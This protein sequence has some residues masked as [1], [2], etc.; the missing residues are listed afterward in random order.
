MH[1]S[2]LIIIYLALQNIIKV[3]KYMMHKI[4]FCTE[5]E[6]NKMSHKC[7]EKVLKEGVGR[8]VDDH[9]MGKKNPHWLKWHPLKSS[10]P[11]CNC[12]LENACQFTEDLPVIF[13][14]VFSIYHSQE[15]NKLSWIQLKGSPNKILD[16]P[17]Y[18]LLTLSS[19]KLYVQIIQMDYS[20]CKVNKSPASDIHM[21]I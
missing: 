16:R 11:H 18:L 6:R 10:L 8:W 12:C 17:L 4:T 3:P 19:A 13:K 7:N 21:V 15:L 1:L 14:F 5:L 20:F 9:H 2:K